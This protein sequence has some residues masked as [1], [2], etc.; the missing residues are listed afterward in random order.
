MITILSVGFPLP[1]I[2]LGLCLLGSYVCASIIANDENIHEK[3]SVNT[4]AS[5]FSSVQND[6]KT[7]K[8]QNIIPAFI[9]SSSKN[10]LQNI[11]PFQKSRYNNKNTYTQMSILKEPPKISN[12]YA[13]PPTSLEALRRRYGTNKEFWGDWSAEQ[14]RTFYKQMLPKAL[15]I[16][17][18]L[19]LSLE[20]RAEIASANRHALRLYSRERCHLPARIVARLYDGLRHLHCFGYWKS[21]GMDWNEVNCHEYFDVICIAIIYVELCLTYYCAI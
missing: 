4:V 10:P 1:F 21:Q 5:E 9:H 17:G 18:A 12:H 11:N 2:L 7:I 13:C 16:D 15:Q 20:Q 19:G 6:M 14:T 8:L 3:Y